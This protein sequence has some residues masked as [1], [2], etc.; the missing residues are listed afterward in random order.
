MSTVGAAVL[1]IAAANA[2]PHSAIRSHDH[3]ALSRVPPPPPLATLLQLPQIVDTLDVVSLRELLRTSRA[4]RAATRSYATPFRYAA[5]VRK[6]LHLAAA[7]IVS[8]A[9][10]ATAADAYCLTVPSPPRQSPPSAIAADLDATVPALPTASTGTSHLP[11]LISPLPLKLQLEQLSN[12]AE[13]ACKGYL[14]TAEM[15]VLAYERAAAALRRLQN[16][17]ASASSLSSSAVVAPQ[18]ETRDEFNANEDEQGDAFF[19]LAAA[20][21][22]QACEIELVSDSP[23]AH[24]RIVLRRFRLW[25]RLGHGF[26]NAIPAAA[27]STVAP[28]ILELREDFANGIITRSWAVLVTSAAPD[29]VPR[30][31]TASATLSALVKKTIG[32]ADA[33]QSAHGVKRWTILRELERGNAAMLMPG[34]LQQRRPQRQHLITQRQQQ[35]LQAQQMSLLH[36]ISRQQH[37][38]QLQQQRQQQQQQLQELQ[39]HQLQQARIQHMRERQQLLIQQRQERQQQQQ[40][41]TQLIQQAAQPPPTRQHRPQPNAPILNAS[42]SADPINRLSG[43]AA[44]LNRILPASSAFSTLGYAATSYHAATA[45]AVEPASIDRWTSALAAAAVRALLVWPLP[46]ATSAVLPVSP[47]LHAAIMHCPLLRDALRAFAVAPDSQASPAP[48]RGV[49]RLDLSRF[50]IAAVVSVVDEALDIVSQS[51]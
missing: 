9:V 20:V 5:A 28:L 48:A 36:Q 1:A 35:Q 42:A 3:V 37:L 27:D 41:L 26:S 2:A 11:P 7:D 47:P 51:L 40:L 50:W 4:V 17:T 24:S 16:A 44:L 23:S 21:L 18:A 29:A 8:C 46:R 38:Q 25:A 12:L 6:A 31:A 32:T 15:W 14:D 30:D 33:E 49:A 45:V 19:S 10:T 43:F 22:A 34:T 39:H 13:N